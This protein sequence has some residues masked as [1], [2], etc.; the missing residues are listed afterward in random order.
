[1]AKKSWI[2]VTP[3]TRWLANAMHGTPQSV[4][5]L[6]L[7]A[8]IGVTAWVIVRGDPIEQLIW[9]AFVIAP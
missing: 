7:A 2:P 6:M 8:F 9:L 5:L 4:I 1:M 3:W